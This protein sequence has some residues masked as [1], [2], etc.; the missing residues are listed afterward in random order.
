[1]KQDLIDLITSGY[2][3]NNQLVGDEIVNYNKL[4]RMNY[5]VIRNLVGEF[6]ESKSDQGDITADSRLNDNY[7]EVEV[8]L[9]EIF[10]DYRT[11]A[12]NGHS[13]KGGQGNHSEGVHNKIWGTFASTYNHVEGNNNNII[14]GGHF[15]FGKNYTNEIDVQ[16]DGKMIDQVSGRSNHIE[17]AGNYIL[18]SDNAH[19]EGKYTAVINSDSGHAEGYHT[20]AYGKASHA[21]GSGSGAPLIATLPISNDYSSNVNMVQSSISS[22]IN[23]KN[24]YNNPA[25]GA[26]ITPS[27]YTL[28]AS[29]AENLDSAIANQFIQYNSR[30]TFIQFLPESKPYFPNAAFGESSHVEGCNNASFEEGSHT[31]G[32]NSTSVSKLSHSEGDSNHTF[33]YG[34][35]AEGGHNITGPFVI[36]DSDGKDVTRYF[37]DNH[38]SSESPNMINGTFNLFSSFDS[39]N[40]TGPK[41]IIDKASFTNN[42]SSYARKFI[43]RTPYQYTSSIDDNYLD[44]YTTDRSLAGVP[45]YGVLPWG[46]EGVSSNSGNISGYQHVEGHSNLAFGNLTHVEGLQNWGISD[47]THIEGYNNLATYGSNRFSGVPEDSLGSTVT[48]TNSSKA[49]HIEGEGNTVFGYGTLHIEGSSNIVTDAA[50]NNGIHIEGCQNIITDA[51]A[52]T[53]IEGLNNFSNYSTNLGA[54]IEGAAF[55]YSNE[56]KNIYDYSSSTYKDVCFSYSTINQLLSP[57]YTSVKYGPTNDTRNYYIKNITVNNEDTSLTVYRQGNSA[58]KR[59][60]HTE[61]SGTAAM[62]IASHAEGSA[63]RFYKPYL[64]SN[65][66]LYNYIYFNTTKA[67][68]SHIE[69]MGNCIYDYS[70]GTTSLGAHVEG[71]RTYIDSNS[72]ASHAEGYC[73]KVYGKASHVEGA[74]T[75][76]SSN[77]AHAEGVATSATS[78]GAHAEGVAVAIN[79]GNQNSNGYYN[80][81]VGESE[82]PRFTYTQSIYFG[83]GSGS[84]GEMIIYNYN[85]TTKTVNT[86]YNENVSNYNYSPDKDCPDYGVPGTVRA[87]APG[88]HAEGAGTQ[89]NTPASHA[90]GIVTASNGY[91]AHAEG[92]LTVST[93]YGTHTEGIGTFAAGYGAHA[94]GIGLYQQGATQIGAH[95]EGMHGVCNAEAGHTEGKECDVSGGIAGHAEG[96]QSKCYGAYG[97]SEGNN[98]LVTQQSGHAGG[99]S[100]NVHGVGGFV[101]GNNLQVTLPY[102]AAFGQF[103]IIDSSSTTLPFG[104]ILFVLGSGTAANDR[105]NALEVDKSGN[106]AIEGDLTFGGGIKLSEVIEELRTSGGGSSSGASYNSADMN[107]Y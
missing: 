55:E 32:K 83:S 38:F 96:Y 28:L 16:A 29:K 68:G 66:W 93:S 25:K 48:V 6:T 47:L 53:H 106:M 8:T 62:G 45:F 100:S 37:A 49:I 27:A 92:I 39:S 35:H 79:T 107:T 94:E 57:P 82:Q 87:N 17:G 7:T 86:L 2:D 76:V 56:Y 65:D 20:L 23:N 4:N 75:Y 67:N 51:S 19:S 46:T 14:T 18:F 41:L 73:T 22:I 88:A 84:V 59:G 64:N 105:K 58:T 54:H 78:L 42:D 44:L 1:M 36:I 71:I 81:P 74:G 103:N 50:F 34:S 61:G 69:G 13:I 80:I 9:N 26:T 11:L 98:C 43:P 70:D 21:E 33:G 99:S 77:A 30:V 31:E 102:Q 97:H 10:N 89:A 5:Q 60:A 101:H 91:G 104:N 85:D 95:V 15:L 24:D 12:N 72:A 52:G 3:L 90:E 40:S 63:Y